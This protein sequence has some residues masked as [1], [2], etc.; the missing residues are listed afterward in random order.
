[1]LLA[2]ARYVVSPGERA[3]VSR[4]RIPRRRMALAAAILVFILVPAGAILVTSLREAS[5]VQIEAGKRLLS[6]GDYERAMGAFSAVLKRQPENVEALWGL[7]TAAYRS[8]DLEK[9]ERVF[10]RAH[11]LSPQD[12]KLRNALDLVRVKKRSGRPPG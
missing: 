12:E 4:A 5:V 10:I 6:E 3:E 2:V 7:G 1:M 9:A 8:G 11:A